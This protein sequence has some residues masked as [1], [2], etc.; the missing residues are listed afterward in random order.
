M[1]QTLLEFSNQSL[2]NLL[3]T[4]REGGEPDADQ[5]DLANGLI[6]LG[7]VGIKD[8]LRDGIADA[9]GKCHRA[10]VTV[11]MITG[12]NKNTAV[13]IAKEAGILDENYKDGECVVMTGK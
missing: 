2:R 6:I 4:Y 1:N 12:D 3:L 7:V 13:A 10:G 11:R 9:V 8:P 5:E